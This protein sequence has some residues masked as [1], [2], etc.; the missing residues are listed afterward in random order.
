MTPSGSELKSQ[1]SSALSS[2]QGPL[3][4]GHSPRS[5]QSK[6]IHSCLTACKEKQKRGD[7]VLLIKQKAGSNHLGL[8]FAELDY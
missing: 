6:M 7:E 1:Q 3:S 8:L 4:L 5:Q 2:F